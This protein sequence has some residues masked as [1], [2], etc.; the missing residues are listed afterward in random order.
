MPNF[1]K[2]AE[3]RRRSFIAG[4]AAESVEAVRKNPKDFKRITTIDVLEN[5]VMIVG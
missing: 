1:K 2:L 4:K 5:N 3:A